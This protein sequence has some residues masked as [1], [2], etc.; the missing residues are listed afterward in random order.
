[1]DEQD[2]PRK[3]STCFAVTAALQVCAPGML[4]S[5]LVPR[6]EILFIHPYAKRTTENKD[7]QM[8]E[9]KHALDND[10]GVNMA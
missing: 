4:L 8:L 6:G 9:I 3:Q 5:G 2:L 1:M 10:E 7:S